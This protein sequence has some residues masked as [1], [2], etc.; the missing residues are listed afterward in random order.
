MPVTRKQLEHIMREHV[1][2]EGEQDYE[3]LRGT[4]HP[5]VEYEVKA[6]SY[7]DDP[8]PYGKF[9]SA[10]VYIE[11]WKRLYRMFA[12]YK[13]EVEDLQ[14]D[15]SCKRAWVRIKAT[16]IPHEEWNGLPRGKPMC[17]WSAAQCDFDDEGRMTKETVYGSFPP[18][19]AGYL[20]MKE[21]VAK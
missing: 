12:S 2:S 16:A 18:V 10:D 4:L 7:P 15:D 5:D 19:M 1:R 11:M 13:I 8:S 17:W 9:Q 21:F 20:R 3:V 6:P 14:I